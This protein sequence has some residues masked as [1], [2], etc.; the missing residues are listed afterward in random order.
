M[1]KDNSMRLFRAIVLGLCL[2]LLCAHLT[3]CGKKGVLYLP[4]KDTHPTHRR[5][6]LLNHKL[7]FIINI[8]HCMQ[9]LSHW[10]R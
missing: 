6:T 9:N 2:A 8:R 1:W 7:C 5:L 10:Q 4:E 3:A